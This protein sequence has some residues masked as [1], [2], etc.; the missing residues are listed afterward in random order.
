M[1]VAEIIENGVDHSAAD[2]SKEEEPSFSD[3]EDYVDD[4]DEDDLVGDVLRLKPSDDE[5]EH[6]CVIVEG[7]PEVDAERLPKLK[8]IL[9][10]IFKRFNDSFTDHYPLDEA[11]KTKGYCF[12]EFPNRSSAADSAQ[13]LNG[14]QLD[15]NH[16]F[17]ANLF[18]DLNKF[19]KPDDNWRPPETKP[20]KDVGD[21]YWWLQN[22]KCMDQFVLHYDRGTAKESYPVVGIY[23]NVP[24]AEPML[25]G[26]EAEKQSWTETIVEWSP[27]GTYLTTFHEKGIALWCG[28]K[29][30]QF[31]RFLHEKVTLIDYS[32]NETYIVTYSQPE[33][34]WS[35]A[36][37]VRVWHVP[38]GVLRRSFSPGIVQQTGRSHLSA[39]PHFQWSQ[40][41]KYFACLK[42]GGGGV[43]IYESE[44]F[45]LVGNKHVIIENLKDFKF[46]PVGHNIAYFVEE[47]GESKP[48]VVAVLRYPWGAG[49]ER[50]VRV[51]KMAEATLYWQK[52]GDRLAVRNDRYSKKKIEE[53]GE[54]KY[55]GMTYHFEIFNLRAKDTPVESLQLSETFVSFGW[56]PF[57]D[58]FCVLT[59]SNLKGTPNI[60][61]AGD[62]GI[63]LLAK[64]DPQQS[65]G[66]NTVLWAPA[67]GWL[68][69][70]GAKTAS[71]SVFFIDTNPAEPIKM[72]SGEH[73]GANEASWDLTGRYFATCSTMFGSK[74][75]DLGYQIFNFQGREVVRKSVDR[76]AQF[77][78]RPRPPVK[79]PEEKT[80]EI[81]RN[82]KAQS[83]K[84]EEEDKREKG[85]ASKEVIDKR[86][87][88]MAEFNNWRSKA[89]ARYDSQKQLRISLRGGVYT[90]E[91]DV[92]ELEEETIEV[93]L[94]TEKIVVE[95]RR[96]DDDE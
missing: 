5:Y 35:D 86:R 53:N 37:T 2:A 68:V 39:W 92:R 19:K 38:T 17:S 48:A 16:K 1:H 25:C 82:M 44:T 71:G 54:I 55:T 9:G 36:E 14:Y 93:P 50:A 52:S 12:V 43:S 84:F 90:D 28:P 57:G 30:E 63:Q 34:R 49:N 67:G 22:P 3:P 74:S 56:E 42:T 27:K 21:P 40:D 7:I 85:R 76:L 75:S 89:R 65:T 58:K 10:K 23:W 31:Q 91:V 94:S 61:R 81:R 70:F 4:I 78:W 73:P 20:F 62:K 88:L 59:G 66:L 46:S 26:D 83:Q 32:P 11:G 60:Y 6:C 77:I 24:G 51:F 15:K 33:S 64:I 80:R 29:F 47:E 79:L 95:K 41:E 45:E 13:V 96:D 18:S 72:N 8:A 69:L 87:R